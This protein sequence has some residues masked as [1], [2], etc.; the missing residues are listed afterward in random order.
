M[1]K[2]V[3]FLIN[4]GLWLIVNERSHFVDEA[5]ESKELVRRRWVDPCQVHPASQRFRLPH[6]NNH[7]PTHLEQG[8]VLVVCNLLYLGTGMAM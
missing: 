4:A 7:Q 2:V 6:A 5:I 3:Q 1:K 8:S